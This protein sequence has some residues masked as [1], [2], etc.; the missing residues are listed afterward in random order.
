[1]LEPKLNID[2]LMWDDKS[3]QA[4]SLAPNTGRAVSGEPWGQ[5]Q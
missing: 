2:T 4:V 5:R 1:M 3:Q